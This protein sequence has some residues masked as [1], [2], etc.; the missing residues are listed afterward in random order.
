MAEC[1]PLKLNGSRPQACVDL[2]CLVEHLSPNPRT[3]LLAEQDKA[4]IRADRLARV[5]R[6][7]AEDHP[8]ARELVDSRGFAGDVPRSPPRQRRDLGPSAI[9]W[10]RVAIAAS[11][12]HALHVGTAGSPP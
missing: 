2:Q 5:A 3:Q 7:V 8:T 10:V 4:R 11:A 9:R 6:A 12:V 1:W